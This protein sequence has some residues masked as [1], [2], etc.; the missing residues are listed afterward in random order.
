MTEQAPGPITMAKPHEGLAPHSYV[1]MRHTQVCQCCGVAS[2]YSRL[3]TRTYLRSSINQAAT[4]GSMLRICDEPPKYRLPIIIEQAKT[5]YVPI[6]SDCDSEALAAYSAALPPVPPPP[7]TVTQIKTAI[8]GSDLVKN[9][10][11]GTRWQDARGN[12]HTTRIDDAKGKTTSTSKPAAPKI[13]TAD[14]LMAAL[15]L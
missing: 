15:K 6:C 5:Q 11:E 3:F 4:N 10:P 13:K 8:L 2:T 14:D 7:E 9:S 12:W 1:I